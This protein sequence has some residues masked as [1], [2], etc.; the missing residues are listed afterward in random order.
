MIHS[1]RAGSIAVVLVLTGTGLL[2]AGTGAEAHTHS[3]SLRP[4]PEQMP[5]NPNTNVGSPALSFSGRYIAYVALTSPGTGTSSSIAR[6]LAVSPT[7]T[8]ACLRRSQVMVPA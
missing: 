3:A 2:G 7:A 1:A 6:S 4:V 5:S 8:T